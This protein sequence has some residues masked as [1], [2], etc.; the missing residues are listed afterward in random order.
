MLSKSHGKPRVDGR[1]VLSGIIFVNGNGLRWREAPRD[2]SLYKTLSNRWKQWA[3]WALRP[4]DE[5]AAAVRA[6]PKTVTIDAA[7]AEGK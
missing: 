4:D 3:R 2:Y 1:L 5:E 7:N 6:E